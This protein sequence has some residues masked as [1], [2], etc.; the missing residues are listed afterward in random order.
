M[1]PIVGD[2][3]LPPD[4]PNGID[5]TPEGHE[6]CEDELKGQ[7]AAVAKALLAL[8]RRGIMNVK[9]NQVVEYLSQQ[10]LVRNYYAH[11]RSRV[12]PP[13]LKALGNEYFIIKTK[14]LPEPQ[15]TGNENGELQHWE[16]RK[17]KNE[18]VEKRELTKAVARALV[19][20]KKANCAESTVPGS[21]KYSAL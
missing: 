6:R 1:P 21:Y 2:A 13:E 8:H 11:A 4:F 15:P 20:I 17:A 3:V 19:A 12:V 5:A 7:N 10:G 16:A 14:N 9:G 18:A